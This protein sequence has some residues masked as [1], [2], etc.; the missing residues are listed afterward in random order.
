MISSN[1]LNGVPLLVLANKQDMP[2]VMGVR[3][4]KPIFNQNAH[5]IG[6]RDCMV[7]PV[8]AL[9]GYGKIVGV[10]SFHNCLIQL[11]NHVLYVNKMLIKFYSG[12]VND[13]ALNTSICFLISPN[14]YL[15]NL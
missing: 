8:S 4:V 5:L 14:K 15:E 13:F 1:C 9:T 11:I 10:T 2:D 12:E 3:E 7:M 6:R